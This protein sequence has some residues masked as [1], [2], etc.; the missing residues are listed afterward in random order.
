MK[1]PAVNRAKLP[2]KWRGAEVV[3]GLG[4]NYEKLRVLVEGSALENFDATRATWLVI[5]DGALQDPGDAVEVKAFH[6]KARALR[7]ARARANGNV[8]QRVLRV[9]EQVLVVATEND[10]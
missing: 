6:T 9:T 1:K 7:Y 5:E 10:L 2:K 8:D 4:M 3:R